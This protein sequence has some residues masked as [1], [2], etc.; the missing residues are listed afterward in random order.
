M[1]NIWGRLQ[2]ADSAV[3]QYFTSVKVASRSD[4]PAGAARSQLMAM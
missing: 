3:R 2:L 4:D 1:G